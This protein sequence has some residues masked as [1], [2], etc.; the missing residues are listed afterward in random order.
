MVVVINKNTQKATVFKENKYL[1]ERLAISKATF[2][3]RLKN[4]PFEVG[5]YTIYNANILP[6]KSNRGGNSGFRG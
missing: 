5:E 3:R 6:K 4:S 2:Y 1:I